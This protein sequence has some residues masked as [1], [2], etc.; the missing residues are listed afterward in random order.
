MSQGVIV[1]GC[2]AIAV[3]LI[4]AVSLWRSDRR[5]GKQDA[6]LRG[7]DTFR[8]ARTA[9]DQAQLVEV[10]ESVRLQKLREA[11][12]SL[13]SLQQFI[14][15]EIQTVEMNRLTVLIDGDPFAGDGVDF[16]AAQ[17]IWPTVEAQVH[18]RLSP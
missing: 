15:P 18:K 13:V 10:E 8:E 11:R 2:V 14:G 1:A 5:K 16:A 17:T 7:I 3:A 9:W 4:G 12:A 6:R